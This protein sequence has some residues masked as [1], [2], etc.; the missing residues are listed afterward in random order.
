M[1]LTIK[2]PRRL[3]AVPELG[4]YEIHVGA[5]AKCHVGLTIVVRRGRN[6]LTGPLLYVPA[7]SQVPPKLVL[8][9]GDFSVALHPANVVMVIPTDYKATVSVSPRTPES[10]TE[11]LVTGPTKPDLHRKV[12][13]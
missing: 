11:G 6:L 7:A 10:L 1:N 9:V 5:L 3:Q 13:L 8:Q 12:N 4:P 2:L